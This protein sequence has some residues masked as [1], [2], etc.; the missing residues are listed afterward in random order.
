MIMNRSACRAV[1]LVLATAALAAPALAART[2]GADAAISHGDDSYARGQLR[3]ALASYQSAEALE[4]DRFAALCGLVRVESELCEDARGDERRRLTASAVEHG[5]DAVKAAPDSA[6]GHV[7]LAVALARQL[8]VEGPKTRAALEREIRS[9]LDRAIAIDPANPRAHFERG[10]WNRRLATLGLWDRAMSKITF[11]GLPNGA[12]LANAVRDLE[13][14][15]E[16]EPNAIDYRL[17]LARTYV[18]AKRD[19]DARRELERALALPAGRPRDPGLQA[20]ARVMLE[21]LSRRG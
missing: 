14:A 13:H 1:V 18:R 8:E 6:A 7:W 4:G 9:E 17:E 11:A 2:N 16:L 20:E 3:E 21:K 10:L 19:A 15:V 12:S 5:R